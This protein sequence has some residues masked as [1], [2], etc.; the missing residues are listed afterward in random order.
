MNCAIK[1]TLH[2]HIILCKNIKM[3]FFFIFMGVQKESQ[4]KNALHEPPLHTEPTWQ[5]LPAPN[6][7]LLAP[8][9][10]FKTSF[11]HCL[12]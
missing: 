12:L 5:L 4:K 8:N 10:L 11:Y 3:N 2:F 6:Q 1:K 7:L 9:E